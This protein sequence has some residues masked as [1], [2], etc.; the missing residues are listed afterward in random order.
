M[1]SNT[2]AVALIFGAGPRIGQ[3]VITRFLAV[4]YRVAAVSRSATDPPAVNDEGVL[5]IRA[6]LQQ[7]SAPRKVLEVVKDIYKAVPSIFIYNSAHQTLA[8]EPDNLF[9]IDTTALNN[10]MLL[11]VSTPWY[12]LHLLFC[13]NLGN[14]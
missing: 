12:E 4:G 9:S 11:M 7:T 2:G 13:W 10:D 14:P 5:C 8:P 1:A 6:D 3:A